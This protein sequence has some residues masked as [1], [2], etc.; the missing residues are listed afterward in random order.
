MSTFRKRTI[1]NLEEL[2][3]QISAIRDQAGPGALL[4]ASRAPLLEVFR[5]HLQQGRERL[6]QSH[7]E[8]ATGVY[9]VRGHA[10]MMDALLRRLYALVRTGNATTLATTP[11][12]EA[13]EQPQPLLQR[14]MRRLKERKERRAQVRPPAQL[15]LVATG[16][17]GR[18]ELAPYSDIDLL[19]LLPE[20]TQS[21][22]SAKVE[23]MLYFLWDLR[24]EV[25]HA[26]R[27]IQE[28]VEL[29]SKEMEIRTSLL[30]SRFLAG[31][32]RLFRRYHTTLMDKTLLGDVEGFQRDKL[33]EQRQRH[34]RF[35]NSM[36]YLE[37][38]IKENPGGLRD[39][40]T[41]V[42]ISE[43][44]YHVKRI[45]DLVEKGIISEEE[46]VTF[47]RC[48]EF[49]LRVRN[50]MH[51]AAGRRD[52]RLTFQ[53][54][55]EIAAAFG[56]R[57][58]P[59]MR[60]VE[61]FMRRYYQVA[62][63]VGNLTYVL[64]QKYQ[65]EQLQ[66]DEEEQELLEDVFILVGDKVAVTHPEAF[67]ENPVRLMR[68]FEVAQRYVKGIHPDTIRLVTRNL[69]LV[70]R[71]FRRN[72]EVNL[73]FLNM[74]SG[75]MSVAWVLRMMNL[76][77]ILGRY[78]PEFGRIIGQSQHDLFHI[79][80]VDEHTIRAV[81]TLRHI[82]SG[83]LEEDLPFF[84]QVMR[85]IRHPVVLHLGVL[86]HDIAKGRGGQHEKAGAVIATDVCA[87]LGLPEW[88]TRQVAWLVA[89]HL[90]FSRTAFRRDI[91][92]PQT[93]VQFSRMVG[94][95]TNLDLLLLLTV[96]DIR[97]V[98]PGVWNQWKA[99]LL[100][101]L[102]H[103]ALEFL[104]KGLYPADE[105]ARQA[106]QKRESVLEILTPDYSPATV[107]N[108]LDRFYSDY[109]VGNEPE[110]IADH[111]IALAEQLHQPLAVA[112]LPNPRSDT[113]TLLVHTMDHAGLFAEISG[114]LAA[115]SANILAANGNLTRDGM[116]F[117]IFVIEEPKGG[118]IRSEEKLSRIEKTLRAVLTGHVHPDQLLA[119]SKMTTRKHELF[120][121]P[122]T[123]EWDNDF[124]DTST[125]LEINALDRLGLLYAV[126]RE[127][128]RQGIQIG[129]AKVSTYGERAVDVFY[130]K[131]MF[132]LKLTETKI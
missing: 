66:S 21:Q 118:A 34:E 43:Y 69:G 113:T 64:L 67:Q 74:L 65:E 115:E 25:G 63:Q 7:Q 110:D 99:N 46:F 104:N 72:P 28:C 22:F 4:A 27:S 2:D 71:E 8:G 62:K 12:R 90:I 60:G 41:F 82:K 39:I 119:G 125:V 37:P 5:Q 81:E 40:H 70:D 15:C 100:L 68:L 26:V 24:L 19:F 86:F 13:P 97:A 73:I 3:R 53:Q 44:R 109:F 98:G 16:G 49:L 89:N 91:N 57:D 18:G 127:M 106:R 48:R 33:V 32:K 35:G 107:N 77:R 17:Y 9:I 83:K 87:R 31:N 111:F 105:L 124:S 94:N 52:D 88:E 85:K 96:A 61:Q 95:Q 80:T 59:H 50:A 20:G 129:T 45:A 84:T 93:V 29:A 114:A 75:R 103:L 78:L 38:N 58:R 76:C 130:L 36:F 101:R 79:F 123:V 102:Y 92:D 54:Q 30:E 51:Y 121:V 6:H 120:E 117:D 128:E 10:Y 116:V 108:Y 112:F 122:S 132:G 1:I 56:Y 126:T 11:A 42:W 131:D 14:L 47:Q 23:W 55:L